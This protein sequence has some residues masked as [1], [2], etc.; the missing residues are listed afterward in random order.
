MRQRTDLEPV[1]PTQERVRP[2]VGSLTF[3][4]GACIAIALVVTATVA[5]MLFRGSQRFTDIVV[6][7]IAL[8]GYNKSADFRLAWVFLLV[9][10]VA[11]A[12]L[13]LV[14]SLRIGPNQP[15]GSRC[16]RMLTAAAP[17]I[18][19]ALMV[20]R[21]LLSET[22]SPPYGTALVLAG[23]AAAVL[24]V[25]I[26]R[27]VG[28]SRERI[29]SVAERVT[30]AIL[31]AGFVF[32][33][34]LGLAGAFAFVS[35]ASRSRSLVEAHAHG[36]V[37][38]FLLAGTVLAIGA[39]TGTI[40]RDRLTRWC[41]AA[42]ILAP[43]VLLQPFIGVHESGGRLFR[44]G[45]TDHARLIASLTVGFGI[46]STFR[47]NRARIHEGEIS[48]RRAILPWA[49]IAVA[50]T[51]VMATPAASA[52][53]MDDDF[54]TGETLIQW[55]QLTTHDHRAFI[56][57]F[58]IPGLLG[59]VIGWINEVLYLGTATSF[60][61]ANL[62]FNVV[63][64][65]LTAALLVRL[66]GAHWA[67]LL[68]TTLLLPSNRT[69]LLLPV[70]LI[71][72]LPGLLHR[73]LLWL[74]VWTAL[75][76]IGTF[77]VSAT[78]LAVTLGT[79][80]LAVWVVGNWLIR[81]RRGDWSIRRQIPQAIPLLL[82]AAAAL[83]FLP[84]LLGLLEY[85]REGEHSNITAYGLGLFQSREAPVLT[86]S[87]PFVVRKTLWEGIRLGAWVVAVPLLLGLL[88]AGMR[89]GRGYIPA[90]GPSSF[91]AFALG[92]LGTLLASIPYTLGRIDAGV[93]SRAGQLSLLTFA[94]LLPV[95]LILYR[96]P[97]ETLTGILI[98]LAWALSLWGFFLP[99][100]PADLVRSAVAPIRTSRPAVFL[101]ESPERFPALG[102]GLI[103][104]KHFG[105]IHKLDRVLRSV[106]RPGETYFDAVNRSTYYFGL[107]R[108]VPTPF[109]SQFYAADEA[110]QQEMLRALTREPPPMI[111]VA[112]RLELRFSLRSYRVYKWAMLQGYRYYR[113]DDL[114][115]LIYPKRASAMD[116]VGATEITDPSAWGPLMQGNLHFIPVSW[117]RSFDS[118]AWRF[119]QPI[120]LRPTGPSAGTNA[121]E[122]VVPPGTPGSRY[123][124]L[125]VEVS[126]SS[127]K[128]AVVRA[129]IKWDVPGW[130]RRVPMR[131]A[132]GRLLVPLGADP[133]WLLEEPRRGLLRIEASRS[134]TCGRLQFESA[135][136]L[137]LE[138]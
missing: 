95:A 132:P 127:G 117:G 134:P 86:T 83:F 2:V 19:I 54:H 15:R 91:A 106:A 84:N 32:V 11:Y 46:V 81:T 123:D 21:W 45:V 65:G 59:A 105:R 78:G 130:T 136:L 121:Q 30:L 74:A 124:F 3:R 36:I 110:F 60:P 118:L 22:R 90:S 92:L 126:C 94:L 131:A 101:E 111:W 87:V 7:E 85:L 99:R 52:F 23:G 41:L 51:A 137:P 20:A 50:A 116:L 122:Y 63:S 4:V 24:A 25:S 57:F 100:R 62:L 38:V 13:G 43:L 66:L 6:G 75:A 17:A 53:E 1:G 40:R 8:G 77:F 16:G 112:P 88:H 119:G 64:A 102:R 97:R 135:S 47:A 14:R 76:A 104:R 39:A 27:V 48:F 73:P 10:F 69:Y 80:P 34:F 133:A 103:N 12:A 113:V 107:G 31:T 79:T 138:V 58:P 96:R 29:R 49:V 67:L 55:P 93:L 70:L 61:Q 28:P 114:D 129:H 71:L 68:A 128:D 82:L 42:Q 35:L 18:V 120:Q 115:I 44:S 108:R 5:P 26:H 89:R 56:T 9:A 72:A 33:S 109:S 37:Q 98:T 125:L